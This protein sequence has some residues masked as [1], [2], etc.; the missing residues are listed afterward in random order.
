M[1]SAAS[2]RSEQELNCWKNALTLLSCFA[3]VM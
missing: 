2:E 3:R 1:L